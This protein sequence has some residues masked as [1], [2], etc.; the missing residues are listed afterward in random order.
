MMDTPV[1]VVCVYCYERKESKKTTQ[2]RMEHSKK[3]KIL[4]TLE[5]SNIY[6][7]NVLWETDLEKEENQKILVFRS[8]FFNGEQL[9]LFNW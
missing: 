9:K 8:L 5:I 2:F 3:W 1:D 4:R 6:V 7:W